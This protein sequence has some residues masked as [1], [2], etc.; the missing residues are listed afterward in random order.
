MASRSEGG[1][2]G[3][4]L[5]PVPLPIFV[6]QVAI[7]HMLL[8]ATGEISEGINSWTQLFDESI[9]DQLKN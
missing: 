9:L 4:G 6:H 7:R 1:H 2:S 8:F 5:E 3:A